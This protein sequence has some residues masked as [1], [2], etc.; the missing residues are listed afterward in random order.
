VLGPT[1]ERRESITGQGV[2]GQW[3]GRQLVLGNEVLM[4]THRVSVEVAASK[5]ILQ[6]DVDVA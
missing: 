5:T 6:K 4:R 2:T 3:E 1:G